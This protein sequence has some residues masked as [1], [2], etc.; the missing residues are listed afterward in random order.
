MVAF[1]LGEKVE[2]GDARA[3]QNGPDELGIHTKPMPT[4]NQRLRQIV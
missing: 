4:V 2:A 3:G 1:G